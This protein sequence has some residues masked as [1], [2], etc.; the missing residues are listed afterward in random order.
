MSVPGDSGRVELTHDRNAT[1]ALVGSILAAMA[2]YG[3][4]EASRFAVRLAV[5]EALSNAFRHGHKGLSAQTPAAVEFRVGAEELTVE[6]EDRGPG[7]RADAVPDP[8][9]DENL[10]LPSGRGLMLI[11]AYMASVTFNATGNR[12]TM[13]YRKPAPKAARSR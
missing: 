2:R 13:V 12:I 4:P 6:I 11:R 10:E 5:E 7:F 3:Y 9:L 8:T 1:D